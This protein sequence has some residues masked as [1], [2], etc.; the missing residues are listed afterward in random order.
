M[1]FLKVFEAGLKQRIPVHSLSVVKL[2]VLCGEAGQSGGV[3]PL[4]SCRTVRACSL[5]G[6]WVGQEPPPSLAACK[7][8]Q[9]TTC[10]PVASGWAVCTGYLLFIHSCWVNKGKLGGMGSFL[11]RQHDNLVRDPRD[12]L[13]AVHSPR[14]PWQQQQQPRRLGF[15]RE[16]TIGKGVSP[17]AREERRRGSLAPGG[18]QTSSQ[19]PK[20]WSTQKPLATNPQ[21]A[22]SRRPRAQRGKLSILRYRKWNTP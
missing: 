14:A 5:G 13:S 12:A 19:T 9:T 16:R 3:S 2:C 8:Y 6:W 7:L 4:R 18:S 20:A 17:L 15:G 11:P 22:A 1:W 10:L 21:L